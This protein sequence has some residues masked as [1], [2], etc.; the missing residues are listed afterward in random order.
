MKHSVYYDILG[1]PL[2]LK[3][4]YETKDK[5]STCDVCFSQKSLYF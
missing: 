1:S 3:L 4:Q 5:R 2:N